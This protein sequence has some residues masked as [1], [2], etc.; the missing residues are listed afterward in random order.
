MPETIVIDR[1]TARRFLVRRTGLG[2]PHDQPWPAPPAGPAGSATPPLSAGRASDAVAVATLQAVRSME[3]IQVDP[4]QV[5]GRNHDLVLAARVRGYRPEVL[6]RLLYGERRLVE[7]IA[8]ERSIVPA[9]D[10]PL[11][12]LRFRRLEEKE[13]PLLT[14]LEPVLNEVLVK[15]RADGPLSSLDFEDDRMLTGWW[16]LDGRP[17]TRVVRQ[18]LEWLWHFGR[19]VIVRRD[20][21]RRVFDLPERGPGL[22]PLTGDELRVLQEGLARKYVRAAGLSTPGRRHFGWFKRPVA[23]RR[24]LAASLVETGELVP[25]EVEGV[26]TPYFVP[27]AEA[28]DLVTAG[29]WDPAPVIRFLPPLDNLIWDRDRTLELFDFD[30]TWEVYT[31]PAKR[32]YGPYTCPILGGDVLVGRIEARLDRRKPASGGRKEGE[33]GPEGGSC[34]VVRGLWWEGKPLAPKEFRRALEEWAA[35]CGAS[36]VSPYAPARKTGYS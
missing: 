34:L 20:G 1:R 13:R 14:N 32:K 15:L 23:E 16:N 22:S 9:E 12:R 31:P 5:V 18:A 30:Y 33:G 25:V 10:Y 29:A 6:D 2:R 4:V 36:D 17:D 19:V 11:F 7:V 21:G 28:G 26:K 35:A 27:A 24:A 8:N 3:Y